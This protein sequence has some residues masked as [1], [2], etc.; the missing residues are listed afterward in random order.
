MRLASIFYGRVQ[1]VYSWGATA[2]RAA[3]ARPG[4][5]ALTW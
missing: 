1:V 4:T 2:G 5:A 3:A